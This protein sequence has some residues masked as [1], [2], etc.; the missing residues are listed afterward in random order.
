M[1]KAHTH[2]HTPRTHTFTHTHT[3]YAYTTKRAHIHTQTRKHTRLVSAKTN[4]TH[5]YTHTHTNR[6]YKHK[7]AHTYDTFCH[8]YAYFCQSFHNIYAPHFPFSVIK[9]KKNSPLIPCPP[10]CTLNYTINIT[11]PF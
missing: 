8:C 4:K 2:T 9:K 6:K 1:Q 3:L 7:P 11:P 5:I 10:P